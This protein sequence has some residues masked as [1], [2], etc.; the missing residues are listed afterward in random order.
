MLMSVVALNL[1]WLNNIYKSIKKAD[2]IS[3][4]DRTVKFV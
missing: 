1:D 2:G 3:I 4:P